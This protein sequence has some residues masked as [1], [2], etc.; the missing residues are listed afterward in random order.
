MF[1]THFYARYFL[2]KQSYYSFRDPGT[3]NPGSDW[4]CS[5]CLQR[6]CFRR[7]NCYKYQK[8]KDPCI[9]VGKKRP[10]SEVFDLNSNS[11]AKH[12]RSENY[13]K[14]AEKR[15]NCDDLVSNSIKCTK[16]QEP[17]IINKSSSKI[18]EKCEILLKLIG[19]PNIS[20]S[21]I[22]DKIASASSF[23]LKCW[24]II[25]QLSTQHLEVM[26]GALN[27][28]SISVIQD[29]YPPIEQIQTAV[30]NYLLGSKGSNEILSKVEMVHN[31]VKKLLAIQWK[32]EKEIVKKELKTILSSTI[33]VLSADLR[34]HFEII[35]SIL[36]TMDSLD[37]PWAIK[38]T[39]KSVQS[40]TNLVEIAAESSS[41]QNV[42]ISWLANVKY[43]QPALLP[44][45]NVPSDKS[46]GVYNSAEEY[47]EIV[48]QLWIG[49]T[50][51]DGNSN[52]NP[53]CCYKFQEKK[54]GQVLL[55]SSEEKYELHCLNSCSF[56]VV[57]QCTNSRHTKGLCSKCAQN[58]KAEL[59][60][61]AG[62]RAST[63]IYDCQVTK[64]DYEGRIYMN[65][66]ESRKPPNQI[67][68]RSTR[69]L[70]S[71]NLVGLVKLSAQGASL[72][73][74]DIIIWGEIVSH[75]D[76]RD[77]FKRREQKCLCVSISTISDSKLMDNIKKDDYLA[78]IDCITFAP[79]HIPVLKALDIQKVSTLP[80]Q[81]GVVYEGQSYGPADFICKEPVNF[82]YICKHVTKM[83]C[84]LAFENASRSNKCHADVE[85]INPDC[86]HPT[87]IKCFQN[88]LLKNLPLKDPI[89]E[90]KEGEITLQFNNHLQN[91]KCTF[92]IL[93]HRRC[94]HNEKIQCFKVKNKHIQVCVV[95]VDINNPLCGH[96]LSLPCH[97]SDLNDWKP[98]K[99]ETCSKFVNNVLFDDCPPPIFPSNELFNYVKRCKSKII[100]RRKYC[101]HQY[102]IDCGVAFNE[103]SNKTLRICSEVIKDAL[104]NCGHKKTMS[105]SSYQIYKNDP[106]SY[107][108]TEQVSMSCWNIK[109]CKE[110]V[111]TECCKRSDRYSCK[112]KIDCT[113]SN[114][115]T[116]KKIPICQDGFLMELWIPYAMLEKAQGKVLVIDEAYN[117]NDKWYGK[118]VLD[119]LVEKVQNTESDDIAVLLLGY[120]PQMRE[121]LREKNPGLARRFAI[122]YPFVFEDYSESKLFVI[123][124]GVC[125]RENIQ[126]SMEASEA[127]LKLLEK[128][129]AQANFG[130]AGAIDNVIC[131]ALA[132]V[133]SRPLTLEGM[134]ELIPSD[135]GGRDA[136]K[137]N[138]SDPFARLNK[139]Y[140]VENIRQQLIEIKNT[141][142]V[143]Q[144]ESSIDRP[145]LGHFVF[146][147]APGTG[148]TTVA[149]VMAEI[150]FDL[151]LL[152]R[153][154]VEVTS[155]LGLTGEFVGHTKKR[156]K[157]KLDAARGGLL[158][159]DEAYELGKGHY[160]EEA[161]TTLVA[162]MT[163]PN[164]KLVIVIAGYPKD[165]EQ[166]LSVN[167]GLK[168]RFKR[169]MNFE[170]WNTNDCI[171]FLRIKAEADN[172]NF[173]VDVKNS[174]H[175]G[176]EELRSYPGW[177]NVR[178]MLALWQKMLEHRANRVVKMPELNKK[179]IKL[180]AMNALKAMVNDRRPK[181]ANAGNIN[182]VLKEA[183]E[184]QIVNQHDHGSQKKLFEVLDE[185]IDDIDVSKRFTKII[186]PLSFTEKI[187]S[188]LEDIRNSGVPDEVWIELQLA[189]IA[190]K[191]EKKNEEE[192]QANEKKFQEDQENLLNELLRE[193]QEER[194]EEKRQ[195][196]L[197]ELEKKREEERKR[198]EAEDIRLK[199]ERQKSKDVENA[200]YKICLCPA[201]YSWYKQG[202]GWRC[203]GGSH[204]VTDEQLQR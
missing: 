62:P 162:A 17:S 157:D 145:E 155:G 184:L 149:R 10:S 56:P 171:N 4:I 45:M 116:I 67:Y 119:V 190:L 104:L 137:F 77:E 164:Y 195:Q 24:E 59:M 58:A 40:S 80:F 146:Q 73:Y 57:L 147:G 97:L 138:G 52:L 175:E 90:I 167:V 13:D 165:M 136:E 14:V 2:Y 142:Q 156:V 35:K 101:G 18:L 130:N 60:G 204:F 91:H 50:F 36:E 22:K 161:I 85:I 189:K 115:H 177:G 122:D 110:K 99:N 43:F 180:D 32:E 42:N 41:W 128:Q 200:I 127:I 202:G 75:G 124:K 48:M 131:D 132:K 139:L 172:Y 82:I 95:S 15:H 199:E 71:A 187:D 29:A 83:A 173:D 103:L 166:M 51:I 96:K 92:N 197:Q 3:G 44:V 181:V 191:E 201:G 111:L 76:P 54:C 70:S 129:R 7:Q 28:V 21:Q 23:W 154:H 79:E 72:N 160:G 33:S 1:L 125:K 26:L 193:L 31:M 141:F 126:M 20:H 64:V 112:K 39:L 108:C 134:I 25:N 11:K 183:S 176:L 144:T 102:S 100:V 61:P 27:K 194:E 19:R 55:P 179:I 182:S 88:Q 178:D 196:M 203:G 86:G 5:N 174:L 89:S 170:D 68:W 81:K 168:S 53:K 120:E 185:S 143:A 105:C 151:G 65:A 66:V 192:R 152:L 74:D 198:R 121:M 49:L 135:I 158:F 34:D 8:D 169:F 63:N 78:V 109:N 84:N 6:N 47:F 140:L 106:E 37:K 30:K 188:D 113:C 69:R 148:K 98:W 123:L 46:S 38:E 117:L 159:I 93:F 163:D 12:Q 16:N 153:N 87:V 9:K 133:S 94:G 118:E 114:G 150:L 107:S 186:N